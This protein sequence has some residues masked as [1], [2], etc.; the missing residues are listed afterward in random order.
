MTASSRSTAVPTTVS[1]PPTSTTSEPLRPINWNL[2]TA[3]EAMVEWID[4]DAG[5]TGSARHTGCRRRW[6]RRSGIAT[7]SWSGSSPRCTRTGSTPT[8]PRAPRRARSGG[9]A[10]SPSARNRLREWVST[11]GHAGSTA[12]GQPG[13]PTWPGEAPVEPGA[14]VEIVDRDADFVSSCSRTSP[15]DAASRNRSAP[16]R[17]RSQHRPSPSCPQPRQLDAGASRRR[18]TRWKSSADPDRKE[19]SMLL[20]HAVTLAE[21]RSYV[22]ALA[23]SARHDRRLDRVRPRPAPDRLHPRRLHPRHQPGPGHR[24]RRAV[25]RSPSRPSRTSPGTASTA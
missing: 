20:A 18:L 1:G 3:D 15:P 13:R 21:A 6:C 12:T 11:R 8:T 23:D 17:S 2:L 4:L 22:A 25:R 14:E 16:P 7:T 9:I 10:T 19:S 5:S 24:P